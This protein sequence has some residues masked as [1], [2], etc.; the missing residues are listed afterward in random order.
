MPAD[1]TGEPLRARQTFGESARSEIELVKQ[2]D[3]EIE[4]VLDVRA[5]PIAEHRLLR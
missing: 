3:G 1:A 4:I 2:R 5:H